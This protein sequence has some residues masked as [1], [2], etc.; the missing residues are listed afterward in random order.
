MDRLLNFYKIPLTPSKVTDEVNAVDADKERPVAVLE[1]E[2]GLVKQTIT[3]L[4]GAG[5]STVAR[6]VRLAKSKKYPDNLAFVSLAADRNELE[7]FINE[8]TYGDGKESPCATQQDLRDVLDHARESRAKSH[9]SSRGR[10]ERRHRSSLS[11]KSSNCSSSRSH[12]SDRSRLSTVARK[13]PCAHKFVLPKTGSP[14]RSNRPM[15]P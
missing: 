3:E 15:S 14:T 1:E 12:S 2:L 7:I 10:R 13:L 8:K 6:L 4:T 11:S 5:I 9:G